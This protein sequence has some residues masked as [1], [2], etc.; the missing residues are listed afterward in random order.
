MNSRRKTVLT[1]LDSLIIFL[2]SYFELLLY[3]DHDK[4]WLHLNTRFE[5]KHTN[6]TQEPEKLTFYFSFP[7]LKSNPLDIPSSIMDYHFLRWKQDIGKQMHCTVIAKRKRDRGEKKRK[8]EKPADPVTLINFGCFKTHHGTTTDLTLKLK[9]KVKKK[10]IIKSVI[11]KTGEG[12]YALTTSTLGYQ[13]GSSVNP[14][15]LLLHSRVI[16]IFKIILQSLN[17]IY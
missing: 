15:I 5:K 2:T 4:N 1:V 14:N 16:S 13:P 11:W 17:H 10:K 8:R 12:D 7:P 6:K 3:L 9:T